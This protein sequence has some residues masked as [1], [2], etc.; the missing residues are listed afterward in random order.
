MLKN[1]FFIFL[2]KYI[3]FNRNLYKYVKKYIFYFL[4]KIY[5]IQ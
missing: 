5:F 2:E 3:L 4:R 1:I